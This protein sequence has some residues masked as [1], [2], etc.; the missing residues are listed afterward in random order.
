MPSLTG[1]RVHIGTYVT[2]EVFAQMEQVRAS[3]RRM[4]RSHW[5]EDA[6]IEKLEREAASFP[7]PTQ[8]ARSGPHSNTA[9]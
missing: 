4:S 1:N 6:I 9:A 5:L 3:H 2:E 7:K 8:D